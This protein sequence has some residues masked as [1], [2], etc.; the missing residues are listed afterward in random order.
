MTLDEIALELGVSK[1]TVSRALSGKG[2]IGKATRQR[3]L[4]YVAEKNPKQDLSI[5]DSGKTH[6]LGVV[7][8]RDEYVTGSA[9]FL[10]CLLGICEAAALLNYNVVLA[11]ATEY[12]TLEVQKLVEQKKVDGII[13]TRDMAIQ[14]LLDSHI[15]VGITGVCN[16]EE[17]IQVDTDNEEAAEKL[18]SI[19][20]RSGY[21]RFALIVGTLSYQVDQSRYQGFRNAISKNGLSMDNQAL[22]VGKFEQDLLDSLIVDMVAKKVECVICAGGILCARLLPRLQSKGFRIPRDI[23]IAS[24][25]DSDTLQNLQPP[26]TAVRISPRM[27]G[28]VMGKQMIQCLQGYEY[29]KKTMIDYEIMLRRSTDRE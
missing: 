18:T 25:Y 3:I 28:N 5:S 20:I 23:A 12:D 13:V 10:E 21:Q 24:L 16:S 22:Y 11:T 6:N 19:L 4:A 26:V 2:R 27:V 15:P 14:Y 8:P 9:F 29:Q 7:F 1:S 17:V